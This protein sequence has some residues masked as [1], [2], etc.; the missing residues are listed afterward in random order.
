MDKNKHTPTPWKMLDV[1]D[2]KNKPIAWSVW[3]DLERPYSNSPRGNQI[4]RTPDG[5]LKERKANAEF[6]IRACNAHYDLLDTCKIAR[7]MFTRI[8][9]G[10]DNGMAKRLDAAIAKAKGEK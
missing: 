6:I 1:M 9:M 4:C 2:L 8:G 7:Q 5:H 3:P 10:D